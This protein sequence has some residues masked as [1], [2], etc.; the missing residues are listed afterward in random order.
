MTVWHFI[1]VAV[2][3]CILMQGVLNKQFSI[4]YGLSTATFINAFVFAALAFLLFVV[5]KK[6]PLSF[7]E[8]LPPK[9]THYEF[10]FWHLIPGACGFVIVMLTPWG[11]H[12]LGAAPVVVLIVSA[13]IVFSFIWDYSVG[14]VSFSIMKVIG[15][16]LVLAGALI[17][18]FM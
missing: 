1:S 12:H 6:F 16:A 17:F 5:A 9:L 8:F 2:G 7:P 18:N 10:R 13:Q 14:S 3:I 15:L 11:I 4:A